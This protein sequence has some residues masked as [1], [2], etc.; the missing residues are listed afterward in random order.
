MQNYA[1]IAKP[2]HELT[3]KGDKFVWTK[4]KDAALINLNEC[5]ITV[6]IL[7]YPDP[8]QAFILDTEA[9]GDAALKEYYLKYR[10]G[11][12]YCRKKRK[13]ILLPRENC[14]Q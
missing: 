10:M 14:W 12:E 8:K 3:N 7:G 11:A 9:S 5:L 4:E 6:P 2:L 13:I 1:T